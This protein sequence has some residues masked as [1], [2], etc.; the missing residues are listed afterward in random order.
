M[1]IGANCYGN[2]WKVLYD[3]ITRHGT[4]RLIA[5]DYS[6]FDNRMSAQMMCAAF[7]VLLRIMRD[8]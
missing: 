1:A 3:H 2:D 5:G 8:N 7:N 4:G 6:K